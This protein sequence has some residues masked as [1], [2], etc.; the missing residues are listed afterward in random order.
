MIWHW[1]S[2]WTTTNEFYYSDLLNILETMSLQE[3]HNDVPSGMWQLVSPRLS[4]T[5]A[6]PYP[7]RKD[8][9]VASVEEWEANSAIA[10]DSEVGVRG[11]P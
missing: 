11:S 5:I 3:I 4:G 8:S 9:D 1:V 6:Y 10:S 7:L 2:V